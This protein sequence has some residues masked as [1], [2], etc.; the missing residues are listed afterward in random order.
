MFA[1]LCQH[2]CQ[3]LAGLSFGVCCL[4]AIMTEAGRGDIC[5]FERQM[6]EISAFSGFQA[7][8]LRNRESA[9]LSRQRKK[10]QLE[11]VEQ[12]CQNLQTQNTQLTGELQEF[13]FW[14]HWG[15]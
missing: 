3:L 11:E 1:M 8:M 14:V 2:R 13:A 12:R 7:R 5:L 15:G 10:M 6:P 4:A 9:H